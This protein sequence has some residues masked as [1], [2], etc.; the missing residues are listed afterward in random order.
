MFSGKAIDGK[1]I[2]FLLFVGA[3]EGSV[4]AIGLNDIRVNKNYFLERLQLAQFL[5]SN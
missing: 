4:L 1:I 2:Q 3:I 5:I